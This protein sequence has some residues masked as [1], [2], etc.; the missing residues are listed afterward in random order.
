V[1]L[2]KQE[3]YQ[4]FVLLH[5]AMKKEIGDNIS[6]SKEDEEVLIK[7]INPL[8]GWQE[9]ALLGWLVLWTSLGIYVTFYLFNAG[10]ER[11]AYIFFIVYLSF[12]GYFEYKA[13]HGYLFKKFGYEL[14]KINK[15]K[16]L[17]KRSLFKRG[18]IK[19]YLRKNIKG[20]RLFEPSKKSFAAAYNKTFWTVGNEQIE[21]DYLG[22]KVSF[23]MHLEEKD[24]RQLTVFLN[25]QLKTIH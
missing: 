5:S 7:I 24:A 16:L 2:L 17:Y 15:E 6:I 18:K 25:R 9:M 10:L 4:K 19:N 22:G 3:Q 21:F 12:W 11:D 8:E 20:F 23:G 13:L 14:I 1:S